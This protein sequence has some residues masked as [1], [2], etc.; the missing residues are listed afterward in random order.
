MFGWL[1]SSSSPLFVVGNTSLFTK[2][3]LTPNDFGR[4]I[5]RLSLRLGV[6]QFDFYQ[7]GC[8]LSPDDVRLLKLV[9]HNTGS[10][11]SLYAS[12]IAGSFLCYAKL[13]LRVPEINIT[14]IESG[15]LSELKLEMA[16]IF[17][18]EQLMNHKNIMVSFSKALES[19]M[20]QD[21]TDSILPQL[22]FRYVYDYYPEFNNG[23]EFKFIPSGLSESLTGLGSRMMA[24]C[25]NNFQLTFQRN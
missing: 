24:I 25:Q 11:Q 19:E 22:F 1:K 7:N 13:L 8:V 15:F 17:S 18:A 14:E 4:E 23:V 20:K 6:S 12:L 3:Q 5:F 21:A 10:M 16:K 9:G 2:K